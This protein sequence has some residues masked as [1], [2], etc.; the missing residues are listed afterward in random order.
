MRTVWILAAAILLTLGPLRGQTTG[1][2]E[3]SVADTQG[4]A[5]TRSAVKLRETLTGATRTVQTGAAG[6]YQARGLTPGIYELEV[7]R[8]NFRTAVRRDIEVAAGQVVR[9]DFVLEVG[10][11]TQVVEVLEQPPLVGTNASDWGGS[12]NRGQLED[13]PLA[14]RDIFDLVNQEAG[15]NVAVNAAA[16]LTTGIGV[17]ISVNGNRPNQNSF[18]LDGIYINDATNS[19]PS[20]SAGRLLLSKMSA[21]KSP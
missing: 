15:A 5:L 16:E 7:S 21:S 19:A 12:I 2:L 4:G 9:A 10:L 14:G 11:E 18:R 8:N 17:Q 3:G 20:S 6:L 13:L 1:A